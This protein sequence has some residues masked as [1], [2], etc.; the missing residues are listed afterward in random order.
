MKYLL[1]STLLLLISLLNPAILVAGGIANSY[2]FEEDGLYYKK[3]D[4]GHAVEVT[5]PPYTYYTDAVVTIPAAVTHDGTTY[6]VTGIA[7]GAFQ[8]DDAM[9]S[10]TIPNSVTRIGQM[11]SSAAMA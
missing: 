10:V 2:D 8:Y 11:A 5:T 4:D 6:P 9:T 7:S 3:I 1:T